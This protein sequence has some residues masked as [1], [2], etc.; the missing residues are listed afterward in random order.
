MKF[1]PNQR[2]KIVRTNCDMDGIEGSVIGVTA[3]HPGMTVFIV[4]L[5]SLYDNGYG[6]GWKA[7]SIT[8]HCL[9]EI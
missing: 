9:E 4:E 6:D 2:V 5:D 8:E 7:I 1:R 3:D